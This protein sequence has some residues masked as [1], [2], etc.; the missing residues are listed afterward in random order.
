MYG[1][2]H[3][4][5]PQVI[6]TVLMLDFTELT[7]AGLSQDENLHDRTFRGHFPKK[8]HVVKIKYDIKHGKVYE[9]ALQKKI[10]FLI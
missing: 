8:C 9:R 6:F 5:T 1:Q 4:Y 10:I 2:T 7:S 3:C